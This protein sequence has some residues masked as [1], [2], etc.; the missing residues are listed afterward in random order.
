M[1]RLSTGLEESDD[2]DEESDSA[3]LAGN[4]TCGSSSP[5]AVDAWRPDKRRDRGR[6]GDLG[7]GLILWLR[8]AVVGARVRDG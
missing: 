8:P 7:R 3:G 5:P 1:I 6:T 4:G 2:D